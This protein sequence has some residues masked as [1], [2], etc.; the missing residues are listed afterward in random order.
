MN[1]GGSALF[2]SVDS[3]LIDRFG[4][5]RVYIFQGSVTPDDIDGIA[6]EPVA[7]RDDL[8]ATPQASFLYRP[9]SHI[10]VLRGIRESLHITSKSAPNAAGR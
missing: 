1:A 4:V 5:N 10:P 2:G 7:T 8:G 6:A 3:S 9:L